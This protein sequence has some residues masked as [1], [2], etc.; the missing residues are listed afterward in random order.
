MKASLHGKRAPAGSFT[1][2]RSLPAARLRRM[3]RA[4]LPAVALALLLGSGCGGGTGN[5]T[6]GS[7]SQKKIALGRRV[8]QQQCATCHQAGGQGVAGVYPT[9][10]GTRWTTGDRGRLIRLVLHGMEG[11]VEVK[12]QTYDQ[13]MQP[14][15]YL[16][17]K[18]VAAVLTYLRQN[19]GNDASAVQASEVA[20]V[21][22]ATTDRDG[23]WT[24]DSLWQATG[25]P[26]ATPDSSARNTGRKA[27][28]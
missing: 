28:R 9:L 11:P 21:R 8:Y 4:R 15:S 1:K 20:A 18:Q 3:I 5:A 14:R 17:D 13:L 24:P 2:V 27:D 7:A 19:F 22:A 6:G 10:H 16:S 26:S 23:P 25:I 12:G